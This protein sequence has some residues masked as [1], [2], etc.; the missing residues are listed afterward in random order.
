[1]K[2]LVASV[3]T[4]V[5]ALLVNCSYALE[6]PKFPEQAKKDWEV[7]VTAEVAKIGP[8]KGAELK[9]ATRNITQDLLVKLPD[10]GRVYL[11]QMMFATYCTAL[12]DDKS[13]TETERSK[14]LKEYI[15]EVRKVTHAQDSTKSKRKQAPGK[16]RLSADT[17]SPAPSPAVE[18]GASVTSSGQTGGITAQNVVINVEEKPKPRTLAADQKKA[19]LG[20]LK[21]EPK[22]AF[23]IKANITV[24]DALSYADQIAEPFRDSGWNVR[25]DNAIITG[26]NVSGV[27]ITIKNPEAVP[28]SCIVLKNALETAGI[29]IRAHYDPG[30]PEVGEVWLSIGSK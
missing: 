7:N 20:F 4:T 30:V 6:C 18:K 27:W 11:E 26:P 1:M 23:V 24:P 17:K 19:I 16:E 22:G 28:P 3:A 10:A 12:R 15:A 2:R 13:L 8:L 25:I 5:L 14:R 29:V 21:N 9:A